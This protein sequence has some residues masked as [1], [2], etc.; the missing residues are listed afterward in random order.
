[1]GGIICTLLKF[2]F[3]EILAVHVGILKHK[4][5]TTTMQNICQNY[6]KDE[7]EKVVIDSFFLNLTC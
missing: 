1:M 3:L 2:T 7:N 4:N 5:K 6:Q